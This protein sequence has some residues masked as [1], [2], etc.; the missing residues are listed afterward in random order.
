MLHFAISCYVCRKKFIAE[1]V[2]VL[3]GY[4]F[5]PEFDLRE[6]TLGQFDTLRFNILFVVVSLA[7]YVICICTQLYHLQYYFI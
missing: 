1:K 5:F 6:R 4:V 7:R 3:F 2:R